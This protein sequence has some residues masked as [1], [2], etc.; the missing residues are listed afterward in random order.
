M[1]GVG[2][3]VRVIV[4]SGV[5]VMVPLAIIWPMALAATLA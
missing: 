5:V 4:I 3:Y 2:E 1:V